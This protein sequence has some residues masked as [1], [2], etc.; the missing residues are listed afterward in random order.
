M[1]GNRGQIVKVCADPA[2][3]I[4]HGDRPSPQ[5]V[6]REREEQRK[7]MEKEKLALAVPY[8]ILAAIL[9]RVTAPL[10]KADVAMIARSFVSHLPAR[11]QAMLAKRHKVTANPI[12]SVEAAFIKAINGCDETALCRLLLEASLMGFASQP[13]EKGQP[14]PLTETAKR[15]RID[16]ER[17]EK[18]VSGELAAK[19][20]KQA[21]KSAKAKAAA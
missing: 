8:R 2:C 15:Y 20:K 6:Q 10:K 3:R 14:D 21:T 11:E 12:T 5:Q 7:R 13:A 18:V 9:Q 1:G 17:I 16:C 4:H 19:Q